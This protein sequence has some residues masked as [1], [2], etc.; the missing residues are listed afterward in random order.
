MTWNIG[1][2]KTVLRNCDVHEGDGEKKMVK[3]RIKD[4]NLM[5]FNKAK[6]KTLHLSRETTKHKDRLDRDG[7]K[8]SLGEKGLGMFVDE[9]LHMTQQFT[10]A[11]QKVDHTLGCNKKEQPACGGR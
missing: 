7:I 10:L 5:K 8:T 3:K 11:A 9:M 4:K 1:S 6:H 2:L